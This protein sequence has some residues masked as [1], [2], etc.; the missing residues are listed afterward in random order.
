MTPNIF[1]LAYLIFTERGIEILG[2]C[3]R[4]RLDM[5]R[6]DRF[7]SRLGAVAG[8]PSSNPATGL[9]SDYVQ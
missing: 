7:E 5:S 4:Y 2:A 3:M 9:A 8:T 1:L 6:Y